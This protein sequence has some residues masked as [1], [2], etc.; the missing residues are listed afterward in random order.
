MEKE[1]N[2]IFWKRYK[3][4]RALKS[5]YTSIIPTIREVARSSGYA[6]AVHGSMTRDL[7]IIAVP[8]VENAV[9]PTTLARR[10]SN[11]VVGKKYWKGFNSLQNWKEKPNQRKAIAIYVGANAY[12]DLSVVPYTICL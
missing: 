9:L 5:F 3:N 11:A 10:I 4:K 12:I 6:I 8:W 2:R 1:E 7:D